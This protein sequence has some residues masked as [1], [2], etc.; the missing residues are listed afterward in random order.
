MKRF[1]ERK[2]VTLGLVGSGALLAAVLIAVNI[3]NLASKL[4]GATSYSA[5]FADA[6]GLSQGNAVT[7]LGAKDGK[8]TSVRLDGTHVLV[9]FE[10][11]HGAVLGNLTRASVSTLTPL[12]TKALK[13][14]PAG[15]GTLASG[16]VIPLERTSSPYDLNEV[17]TELTT[18]TGAIDTKRLSEALNTVTDTFSG[19]S[20]EIGPALAG[21]TR[22]SETVSSRDVQLR[23]LL[24]NSNRVTG[25]LA[26]RN[27][28]LIR[29]MEDGNLFFAELQRRSDEISK[30]LV[31]VSAMADQL[32][33]VATD[34]K[35]QLKP[36]LDQF[37]L[38]LDV[39]QK[40]KANI[41]AIIQKSG[42]YIQSVG[43]AVG[44]GP[45]FD[46]YIGNLVP[47]NM[48]PR[49]LPTLRGSPPPLDEQPGP[50]GVLGLP[51]VPGLKPYPTGPNPP[52]PANVPVK[53][54]GGR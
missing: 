35:Q 48:V 19:T 53:P 28:E 40:N 50:P 42:P 45:F 43:E 18:T 46:A 26:G 16:S 13:L 9:S 7:V 38:A 3:G 8:I 54:G 29:L 32:S 24:G 41:E 2:Q 51:H 20:T 6:G 44:S 10:V 14:V 1:S 30:L 15:T 23:Q 11:N 21:L 49:L 27:S 4:G 25:V 37:N 39:L 34:N 17:L 22:L 12:G 33:G 31:S 52:P 47:T 36:A 5:V